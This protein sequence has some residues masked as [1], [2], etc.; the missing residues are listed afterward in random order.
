[1]QD[2]PGSGIRFRPPSKGLKARA[3]HKVQQTR[4]R[5]V[6]LLAMQAL[7][8]HSPRGG[9]ADT[10]S[11]QLHESLPTTLCLHAHPQHDDYG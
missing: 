5:Q 4:P 7:Y 8:A 10:G 11:A 1:M 9:L 2:W 6:T 3:A